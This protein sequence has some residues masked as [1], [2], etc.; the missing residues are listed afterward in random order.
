MENR[1]MEE[2]DILAKQNEIDDTN[3]QCNKCMEFQ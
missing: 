1:K 3:E 2:L